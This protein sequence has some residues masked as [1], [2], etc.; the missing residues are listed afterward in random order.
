MAQPD[1]GEAGP[2]SITPP[3]PAS[4]IET[5][6]PVLFRQRADDRLTPVAAARTPVQR[7]VVVAIRARPG[8]LAR[9]ARREPT[10]HPTLSRPVSHRT[11]ASRTPA[12]HCRIEKSGGSP[13]L[14]ASLKPRPGCLDGYRPSRAL[15]AFLSGV[16]ECR[17]VSSH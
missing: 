12:H 2:G 1:A 6:V 7:L 8:E 14:I 17:H 16:P 9:I 10:W 4:D 3:A 13:R 5:G 11:E 15:L